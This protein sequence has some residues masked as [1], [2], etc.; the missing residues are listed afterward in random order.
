MTDDKSAKLI[1]WIYLA[2]VWVTVFTGFGNMPLWKRYYIAD[3]PVMAWSG[4]FLV[5]VQVHYLFGSVILAIAVYFT[6]LYINEQR[7]G[8]RLTRTGLIRAVLLGL[9][10]V[11]GILQVLK[12]FP[13]VNPSF[14]MMVFLNLFHMG[15]AV[16]FFLFAIGCLVARSRWIMSPEGGI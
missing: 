16:L 10:L 5:N 13:A 8:L 9:T 6:I 15:T 11:S 3:I 7:S 4:D 1:K 12:N 2:A 14:E